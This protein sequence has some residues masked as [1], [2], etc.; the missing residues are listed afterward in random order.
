MTALATVIG[1]LPIALKWG[2]GSEASAPLA[3]AAIGGLAVSTLLT[4]VLVPA[5]YELFYSWREAG[6]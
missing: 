6:R 5:I 2:A 1:L 3:R 4:L